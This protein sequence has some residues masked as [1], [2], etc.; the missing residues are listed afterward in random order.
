VPLPHISCAEFELSWTASTDDVTP[1]DLI[2]YD[3]FVNGRLSDVQVGSGARSINDGNFGE[4]TL[5]R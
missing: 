1:Q 4:S 3:V 2:R 5:S